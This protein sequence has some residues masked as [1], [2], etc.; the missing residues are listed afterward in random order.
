MLS[1]DN[2]PRYD[3]RQ[4]KLNMFFIIKESR[5]SYL[6]RNKHVIRYEISDYHYTKCCQVS[7]ATATK[8]SLR[9]G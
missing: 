3:S 6:S 5:D 9:K 1:K 4:I 8:I 7:K 2:Y